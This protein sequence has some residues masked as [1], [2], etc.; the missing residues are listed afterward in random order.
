VFE[1]TVFVLVD[2]PYFIAIGP[3]A[4]C[5]CNLN[6]VVVSY[7]ICTNQLPF[8]TIG[9]NTTALLTTCTKQEQLAVIQ[10]LWAEG[11]TGGNI[12]FEGI[13]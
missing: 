3:T 11:V 1:I 7:L 9:V 2:P 6:T 8:N 10:T 12:H 4:Q 13:L 5:G